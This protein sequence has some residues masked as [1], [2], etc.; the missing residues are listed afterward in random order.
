MTNKARM[1]KLPL[2]RSKNHQFAPF[3]TIFTTVPTLN[4]KLSIF[5][6]T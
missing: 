3:P 5:T 2:A 1:D 4:E 6:H